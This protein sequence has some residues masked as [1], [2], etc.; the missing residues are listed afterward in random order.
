MLCRIGCL[1]LTPSPLAR[2]P[3]P[4][5]QR[6]IG[7]V[8]FR[9]DLG[10]SD[11]LVAI[12]RKG[13]MSDPGLASVAAKT[14]Y[15]LALHRTS[16]KCGEDASESKCGGGGEGGAVEEEE[17]KA[18]EEGGDE[19]DGDG[20]CSFEPAVHD[21]LVGTLEE[22]VEMFDEEEEETEFI[23]VARALMGV[24]LG[25]R[26]GAAAC[27]Q[28]DSDMVPLDDPTE[29]DT[30]GGDDDKGEIGGGGVFGDEADPD[31][32]RSQRK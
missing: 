11:K 3:P 4:L 24:L 26:A 6:R 1:L 19:E 18:G 29:E 30:H 5:L 8:L 14:L 22:F 2:P 32:W 27:C 25:P 23:Q 15:N 12:I 7:Q 9:R 16:V 17:G 31:G 13:G 20:A 10:A 21:R 28:D